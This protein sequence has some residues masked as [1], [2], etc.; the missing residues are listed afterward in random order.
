MGVY[1]NL[2]RESKK[3]EHHKMRQNKMDM[4]EQVRGLGDTYTHQKW[5][6]TTTSGGALVRDCDG[7]GAWGGVGGA[8]NERGCRG[9]LIGAEKEGDRGLMA[10][11]EGSPETVMH[12]GVWR[13]SGEELHQPGGVGWCGV[14]GNRRRGSGLLIGAEKERIGGH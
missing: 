13:S 1:G 8:G 11:I 14:C 7:L 12:D 2:A 4:K 6:R 5:R 3:E 9:L 10:R